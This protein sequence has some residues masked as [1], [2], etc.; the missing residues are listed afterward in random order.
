VTKSTRSF[1]FGRIV[2]VCI[3]STAGWFKRGTQIND[4]KAE[5][6]EIQRDLRQVVVLLA[7]LM[8]VKQIKL[9]TVQ[10]QIPE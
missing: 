4:L 2:G 6:R 9:L 3:T 5:S 8:Q 1:V 10:K 7:S